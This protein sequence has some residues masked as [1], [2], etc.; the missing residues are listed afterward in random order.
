MRQILVAGVVAAALGGCVVAPTGNQAPASAPASAAASASGP[1]TSLT[2][3]A[4]PSSPPSSSQAAAKPQAPPPVDNGTAV[5]HAVGTPI[6][7]LA[8][9]PIC[10]LTV[11][12]A[13][14]M[15]AASQ[16]SGDP[17][18]SDTRRSLAEGIDQNCGPPYSL[19]P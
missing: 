16:L 12:I 4:P 8:K 17:H 18:G 11:L 14:P 1:P 9:V 6:L 19:L 5:L 10:L 15:A 13:A 2:A 7:I 3:P